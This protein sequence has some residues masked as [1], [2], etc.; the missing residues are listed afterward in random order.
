VRAQAQSLIAVDFFTVETVWLKRLCV[1][2][3]IEHGRRR[4]HLAGCTANPTGAWMTQQAR[5]LAWTL[6]DRATPPRV[7]LRDRDSKP[8]RDFD[9]VLQSEGLEI[10]RTPLRAPTANAIA[11]RFVRT[12]RS[13]CRDWLFVLN[14]RHL[15]QVP[16]V[17]VEHYN[18][19]RPH[20]SLASRRRTR[21]DRQC[22]S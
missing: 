20:R 7:L 22:G 8:T 16:S 9:T 12:A 2:F 4:V 14:R 10:V 6:A 19:H 18:S 3:F 5:R 1:L 21:V 13:E 17:F 11:E 15:E